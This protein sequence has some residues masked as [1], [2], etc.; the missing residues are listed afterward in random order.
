M[1]NQ[2]EMKKQKYLEALLTSSTQKEAYTKAHISKATANRYDSDPDFKQA[3]RKERRK[4]ME[5]TGN[6]LRKLTSKAV[7]TLSNIMDDAEAS[8]TDKAR[9]AKIVLDNS[10]HVE[11]VQDIEERLDDLE[12]KESTD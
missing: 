3:Y 11:Q 2:T 10:F 4:V 9:A 5:F 1:T 6:R 8:P 7:D 12:E